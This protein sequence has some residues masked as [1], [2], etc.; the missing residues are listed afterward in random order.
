MLGLE[1]EEIHQ[2]SSGWSP[3]FV[4][5]NLG[6]M[7][8]GFMLQGAD[9]PVIWRGP[10]KNGLIKQ[11]LR[12]VDWGELDYLVID[13]PPGHTHTPTP[14]PPPPF[15]PS[16]GRVSWD[17]SN[18]PSAAYLSIISVAFLPPV[19]HN[20]F[21]MSRIPQQTS[22]IRHSVVSACVQGL[23]LTCIAHP[24]FCGDVGDCLPRSQ[25]M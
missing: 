2:S 18:L 20:I 19:G 23:Q 1:G 15:P 13:S 3:V 9:D 24:F 6:V 21:P 22:E 12:D 17:D 4:E 16:L 11:F 25:T 5:D 8:I 14:P 7:S 10:R